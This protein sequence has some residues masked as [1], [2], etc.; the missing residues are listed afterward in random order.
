MQT[1]QKGGKKEVGKKASP[2]GKKVAPKGRQPG[3]EGKKGKEYF[4]G[5][6]LRDQLKMLED[7]DYDPNHKDHPSHFNQEYVYPDSVLHPDNPDK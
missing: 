7:P 2:G 1:K 4:V 5:F 3:P 6:S